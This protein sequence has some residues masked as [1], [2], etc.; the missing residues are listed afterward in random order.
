MSVDITI[1]SIED[2][3]FKDLSRIIENRKKMISYQASNGVIQLFWEVG[4]KINEDILNNQRAEYGK[5]IVVSVTRQLQAKFGRAFNEKN[6]RR[7]MQ[8]ATQFPQ[9][10]TVSKFPM[11]LSS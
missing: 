9:I 11:Q 3:L 6:V 7:M 8:F 1:E 10:K 2:R 4:K 5:Q